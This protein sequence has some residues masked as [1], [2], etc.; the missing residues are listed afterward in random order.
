MKNDGGAITGAAS[1]SRIRH[2]CRSDFHAWRRARLPASI[3]EP[4]RLA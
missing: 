1:G 2:V 4:D 3:Y